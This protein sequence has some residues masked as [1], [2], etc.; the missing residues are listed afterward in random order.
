MERSARSVCG[1]TDRVRAATTTVT[2]RAP[3]RPG[4]ERPAET[5]SSRRTRA[6]R[7]QG[8]NLDR[9]Y[10]PVSLEGAVGAVWQRKRRR[11][12]HRRAGHFSPAVYFRLLRIQF[13]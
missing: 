2:A 11:R 7:L 4:E 3:G 12:K 1:E 8:G 9:Q 5:G 13:A 10:R 6:E